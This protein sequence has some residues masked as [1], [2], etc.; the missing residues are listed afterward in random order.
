MRTDKQKAKL[1]LAHTQFRNACSNLHDASYS[2]KSPEREAKTL[3]LSITH[4]LQ[5][6]SLYR[7]QIE[8]NLQEFLASLQAREAGEKAANLATIDRA[9]TGVTVTPGSPT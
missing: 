8:A 2:A 7:P 3:I 5:F 6:G 1:R 4:A 9:N